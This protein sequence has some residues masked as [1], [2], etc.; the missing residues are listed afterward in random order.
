ME[1]KMDYCPK[2]KM[3][4]LIK[5][6]EMQT[7]MSCGYKKMNIDYHSVVYPLM[8][9][10]AL[11]NH[12]FDILYQINEDIQKIYQTNL[13]IEALSYL[14]ERGFNN[15]DIERFG[16]GYTRGKDVEKLLLK[17]PKDLLVTAGLLNPKTGKDFF[18]YRIMIPIR[19]NRH[20]IIGFG[21]RVLDNSKPKY[22]NTPETPIFHK[23]SVFYGIHEL[24]LSS[25]SI[26][27]CEGY[28]DVIS[29][30][31]YGFNNALAGMGT[32]LTDNHALIIKQLEKKI[33]CMYDSDD[34]GINAT[35][36]NMNLL[37]TYQ[38]PCASI[39]LNPYKDPDEFLKSESI[40]SMN[41]RLKHPCTQNQIQIQQENVLDIN[42]WIFAVFNELGKYK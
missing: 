25:D 31:K 29:M 27:L 42:N 18:F 41:E 5:Y 16:F 36:K 39:N 24:D 13:D 12:S 10:K 2:C 37:G 8:H 34:A 4:S 30:H 35:L 19:D 33:L 15:D 6:N 7:C 26:I 20:R 14:K 9:N 21:G 32:A 28:M 40:D 22:I 23:S 11:H 1:F 3:Y 38:I 17:Y